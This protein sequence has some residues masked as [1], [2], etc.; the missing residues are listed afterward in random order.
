MKGLSFVV[1]SAMLAMMLAGHSTA[2]ARSKR[3]AQDPQPKRDPI[4]EKFVNLQVLPKDITKP[5]LVSVMKQFCITFHVRC[6]Y[7]HEV[8]DDLTQ[9]AFDS[10]GKETKQQTRELLKSIYSAGGRLRS[11]FQPRLRLHPRRGDQNDRPV[12]SRIP[13]SGCARDAC[14]CSR[15]IPALNRIFRERERVKRQLQQVRMG[16]HV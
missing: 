10:D 11:S 6:A 15:P 8:S 3:S 2:V 4:P 16:R 7:C 9:G 1:V 13:P 5:Q 14:A 12:D